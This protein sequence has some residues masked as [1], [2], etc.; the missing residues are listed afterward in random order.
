MHRYSREEIVARALSQL[1]K[2]GEYHLLMRNCQHFT[3]WCQGHITS[4]RDISTYISLAAALVVSGKG[5]SVG[6]NYLGLKGS[7]VGFIVGAVVGAF[8]GLLGMETFVRAHDSASKGP[9][10]HLKWLQ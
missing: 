6:K 9:S 4:S 8:V 5:I 3:T 7:L 10:G 2:A 1:G